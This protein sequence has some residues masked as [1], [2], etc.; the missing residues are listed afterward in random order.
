M[1]YLHC[2]YDMYTCGFRINVN[3][4]MEGTCICFFFGKRRDKAHEGEDM[5]TIGYSEIQFLLLVQWLYVM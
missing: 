2:T 5:I 1:K 4:V 3:F